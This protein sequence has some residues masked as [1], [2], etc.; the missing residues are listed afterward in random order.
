MNTLSRIVA[1]A[2]GLVCLTAAGFGLAAITHD[3][4]AGLFITVSGVT[5][6][7]ILLMAAFAEDE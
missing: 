1:V 2:F 7:L 6:G 4:V 3:Y 5:S